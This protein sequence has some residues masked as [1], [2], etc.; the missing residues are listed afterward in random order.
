[1]DNL[2]SA[3]Y[4]LAI[5][6]G[7]GDGTQFEPEKAVTRAQ[8]ASFITRTLAHT[9]VRPAGL[10]GQSVGPVVRVSL[11]DADFNPIVNEW[12]D[13]FSVDAGREDDAFSDS[14][15]CSRLPNPHPEGSTRCRVER[16]DMLTQPDGD[17]V[18]AIPTGDVGDGL[19]LWAWTGDVGD[20]FG[21]DTEPVVELDVTLGDLIPN[22]ALVSSDLAP[23]A[24][25]A[26]FGATIRHS[27]QLQ[28][29]DNQI[30]AVD[31]G[32]GNEDFEYSLALELMSDDERL[33]QQGQ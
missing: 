3:A 29:H 27:V 12:I 33:D 14:G 16:S 17:V 4:E 18:F 2:I 31:V 25:K 15:S 32:P 7:T 10:S 26:R 24:S 6:N 11:R 9:T 21:D 8:M 30:G 5:S 28:Y 23:G 1:M 13:A 20:R 19:T 22:R